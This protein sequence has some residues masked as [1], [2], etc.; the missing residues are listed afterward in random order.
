MPPADLEIACRL[1]CKRHR[2]ARRQNVTWKLALA[3]G[4]H[5]SGSDYQ[6]HGADGRRNFFA[7]MRLNSD[8]DISCLDTMI[9]GVR[10]RDEKRQD[11][12]NRYRQPH[13]KQSLHKKTS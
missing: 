4:D 5:E 1:L 10:N 12:Q 7:V 9:F 8:V 3:A 2:L 11:S 13:D 6:D